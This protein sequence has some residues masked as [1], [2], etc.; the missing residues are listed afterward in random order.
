MYRSVDFSAGATSAGRS[1]IRHAI[2]SRM[3]WS[4]QAVIEPGRLIYRGRLGTA[5][6]H[7]HAA[8]QIA[9]ATDATP[10]LFTD[11]RGQRASALAGIIPAGTAHALDAADT[12]GLMV[13]LEPTTS[14][15]RLVSALVD[16]QT[17]A[18]CSS[19]TTAAATLSPN[20]AGQEHLSDAADAVLRT[21][22]GHTR[23]SAAPDEFIHPGVQ[24]VVALIPQLI[25]G[26]IRLT[27]MAAAVYLSPD[28]LGRLFA[29]D[30]GLSLSA[31]V[32]WARLIRTME[33][34]RGGGTI[35]DAA[36]AAGF[37]DSSHA[38]RAFHEM[39]GI[40]PISAFRGVNL[41]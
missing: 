20:S 39:F 41:Q 9:V 23:T 35:T 1:G 27:E 17:R 32:R 11:A 30:V 25:T 33:V 29:R 21:L 5:H 4:G 40:A 38:N 7:A 18:S 24:Q 16:K 36:H 2:L 26:P 6:H 3:Q 15:G 8:V 37:S 22:L 12:T 19:W 14:A 31:Y 28:R 10:L 34:A 13:Y